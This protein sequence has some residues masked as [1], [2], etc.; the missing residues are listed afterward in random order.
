MAITYK[1]SL[2]DPHNS[3]KTQFV[4]FERL[5]IT[6]AIDIKQIGLCLRG[7]RSFK[8]SGFPFISK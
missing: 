8:I 4:S 1:T 5:N 7:N 3:G 2:S 6:G